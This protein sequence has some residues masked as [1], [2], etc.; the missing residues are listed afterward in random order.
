MAFK[1]ES[2]MFFLPVLVTALTTTAKV[3]LFTIGVT[4]AA[5]IKK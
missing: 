1:E 5:T 3:E 2:V 4:T